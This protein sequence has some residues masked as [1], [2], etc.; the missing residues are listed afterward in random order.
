MDG[1]QAGSGECVWWFLSCTWLIPRLAARTL[2]AQ[3][4]LSRIGKTKTGTPGLGLIHARYRRGNR[5]LA[6][7]L[8]PQLV[9]FGHMYLGKDIT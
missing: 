5:G 8:S 2:Q 3:H 7:Q 9:V 4:N 1:G 6:R